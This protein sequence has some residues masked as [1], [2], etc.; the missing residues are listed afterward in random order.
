MVSKKQ[1]FRIL[2]ESP[3]RPGH[4]IIE[5]HN[6]QPHLFI[7]SR[8]VVTSS[9]LNPDFIDVL[10]RSESWRSVKDDHWLSL[11]ELGED[12]RGA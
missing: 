2:A 11:D 7:G 6:G 5:D 8:G 4:L 3:K 10:L 1:T 12:A 9:P